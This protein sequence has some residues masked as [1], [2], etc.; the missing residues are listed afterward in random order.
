MNDY[1]DEYVIANSADSHLRK[2]GFLAK[3]LDLVKDIANGVCVRECPSCGGSGDVYDWN[4]GEGVTCEVC[5]GSGKVVWAV[6][7]RPYDPNAPQPE[8]D[9]D[10]IPF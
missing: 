9:L 2:I 10:D 1:I 4:A 5:G 7:C 8:I 6:T 3:Y